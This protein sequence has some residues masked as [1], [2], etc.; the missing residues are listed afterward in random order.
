MNEL[1]IAVPVTLRYAIAVTSAGQPVELL[2]PEHPLCNYSR[3]VQEIREA[4][5]VGLWMGS[6]RKIA[7]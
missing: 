5:T 7:P 2:N 4:Q 3:S 6:P 1:S